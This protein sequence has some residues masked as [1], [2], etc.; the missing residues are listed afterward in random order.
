MVIPGADRGRPEEPIRLVPHD[1]SWPGK[2]EAERELLEEAIGPWI[3]GGIHHIGSTAVPG[4]E[5]K[6]VIDIMVGVRGLE[7]SQACFE[8]L[9]RL[10]YVHFPY[11]PEERHWFCKPDPAARTHH[12]HLVPAGS[13]RFRDHLA[14]RDRLRADP[15]LARRYA[16]LKRELAARFEHDR[17]AYTSGKDDFVRRALAEAPGGE[18]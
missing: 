10:G 18:G 15:E 4:L 2:F 8:P 13:R 17:E 3:V 6:P 9:A 7:E 1:P 11:L 12:L 5:A 16:G 14:F